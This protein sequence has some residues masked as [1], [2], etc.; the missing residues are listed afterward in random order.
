MKV[1]QSLFKRIFS[2]PY[3]RDDIE[4]EI[5]HEDDEPT[6]GHDEPIADNGDNEDDTLVEY[7]NEDETD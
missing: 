1:S 3:T 6:A 2:F 7:V 4:P 5:I